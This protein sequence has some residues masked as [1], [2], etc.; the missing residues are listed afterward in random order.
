[1]VNLKKRLTMPL[2]KTYHPLW[3]SFWHKS[4]VNRSL[5]QDR[6]QMMNSPIDSRLPN[7]DT[8]KNLSQIAWYVDII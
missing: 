7:P 8:Q 1:M 6:Q 3:D 2:F 5:F 4:K